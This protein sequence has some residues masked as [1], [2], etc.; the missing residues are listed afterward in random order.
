MILTKIIYIGQCTKTDN[1]GGGVHR[2]ITVNKETLK[3]I[4]TEITQ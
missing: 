2:G 1:G 4:E 3:I